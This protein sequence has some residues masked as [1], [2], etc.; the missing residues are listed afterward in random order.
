MSNFVF[1]NKDGRGN[2]YDEC[3][4]DA[5]DTVDEEGDPHAIKQLVNLDSYL[6]TKSA[7][8]SFNEPDEQESEVE[9]TTMKDDPKRPKT[10]T[11]YCTTPRDLFFRYKL[12]EL[13]SIRAAA[14]KAGVKETTARYW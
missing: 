6:K 7:S 4:A 9:D 14:I 12:Q 11:N 10:C 8:A 5:M 3:G 13:P 1:L 2:T